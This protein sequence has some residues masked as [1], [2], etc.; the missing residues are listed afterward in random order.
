MAHDGNF[1]PVQTAVQSIAGE[2]GSNLIALADLNALITSLK[3]SIKET[4]QPE[5]SAGGHTGELNN[6][7]KMV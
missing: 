2:L 4:G 1:A 5:S 7:C 3:E 6:W